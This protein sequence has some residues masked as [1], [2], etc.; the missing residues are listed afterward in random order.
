MTDPAAEARVDA[1]L[2]A[3]AL[4]DS[5]KAAFGQLVRRHQGQLRARVRRL[6]RADAAWADDIA[7]ETFIMAWRK[8]D[9]FRA[10]ARFSTW[11]YRIAYTLFLQAKRGKRIDFDS[12]TAEDVGR[13]DPFRGFALRRDLSK[14]LESLPDVQSTA[15][16]LCYDCD[17]S[18]EDAAYVLGIPVGTVKSHIS[19]GK[20]RLR[21]QLSAWQD[22][23]AD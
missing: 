20:Q 17:L 8:L 23:V 4:R 2:I 18:H 16:T 5:D 6:T 12:R 22:S 7:Q 13:E 9:Q 21:E 1:A 11:L 10:E 19:R 15:L 14:A 3:R